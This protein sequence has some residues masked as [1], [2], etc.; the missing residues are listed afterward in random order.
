MKKY[1]LSQIMKAAWNIRRTANVD[2]STALKS[3]WALVKA[4]MTAEQDGKNCGWNYRVKV[5]DWTKGGHN[6]TYVSLRIYTNAWN[7]KRERN[8]GYVNNL[9]GEFVAA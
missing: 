2:M 7:L 8:I 9:T 1:N 6:R 5:N 3:A 4:T